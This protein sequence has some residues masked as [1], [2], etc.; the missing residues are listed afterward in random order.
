MITAV[1]SVIFDCYANYMGTKTNGISC[2]NRILPSIVQFETYAVDRI[3]NHERNIYST[4]HFT[5]S[6]AV[7][8]K[9]PDSILTIDLITAF[10]GRYQFV[11]GSRL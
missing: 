5:A 9:Q 4:G 2:K 6:N 7:C 1:K 3:E 11:T 8:S 10:L